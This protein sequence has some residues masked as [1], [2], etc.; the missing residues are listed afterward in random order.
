MA[1]VRREL[2]TQLRRLPSFVCLLLFLSAAIA[3]VLLAWPPEETLLSNAGTASNLLVQCLAF[4]LMGGC[5]LFVPSIAA[6]AIVGEKERET[7]DMLFLTL[8]RPSSIIIAKL[9]NTV[10]FFILLLV[11]VLPV[12]ACLFFLVGI[13]WGQLAAILVLVLA[14]VVTCAFVGLLSSA[15]FRRTF[16]A[17]VGAFIGMSVVM[18]I[19]PQFF[20]G[21]LMAIFGLRGSGRLIVLLA[22][23]HPLIA[24]QT[25]IADGVSV[26]LFLR[27][28]PQQLIICV[29][30][31]V[32]LL[33][34]LRRP[35]K[36]AHVD[37]R[38]PIDD[39]ELLHARRRRFPYYLIDP[40][41]RR[42]PIDDAHNPVAIRELR[43]G[44]F[45]R[46][47]RLIRLFYLTI[48][49]LFG[50]GISVGILQR[51][52]RSWMLIQFAL[53][54]VGTPALLANTLTKEHE[55]GNID[56]LR[57]T[58]LTP[59]QVIA[60]KFV[61]G[62]LTMAPTLAACLVAGVLMG[63][64]AVWWDDRPAPLLIGYPCLI[65]CAF[66]SLA[67]TFFASSSTRRTSVALLAS[68]LGSAVLFF[69]GL[70]VWQAVGIVEPALHKQDL[71]SYISPVTTFMRLAGMK[72][73]SLWRPERFPVWL[74]LVPVL[75]V[76][77]FFGRVLLAL[78]TQSFKRR[79][80]R[81]GAS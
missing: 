22:G 31:F 35:P 30:S 52:L 65:V 28:L 54:L 56:M 34:L 50:T 66:E 76:H 16:L 18:G 79:G 33:L 19:G 25:V 17:I 1:L 5:V 26:G 72:P 3:A 24:I 71:G 46:E 39:P 78:A 81:G 42:P 68:Y 10:A 63:F 64:G 48:I 49:I 40:L 61:A 47:T 62:V 6:N 36:P 4:V 44:L 58:L 74:A 7:Y 11:A 75:V 29:I 8:L 23:V 27:V 20:H 73:R 32:A 45:G 9:I 38:K 14:A 43:H 69:G 37:F 80:V 51:D 70:L 13:D 21:I 2:L 53:I 57:M 12:F 59:G 55:L 41:R 67:L 60:G 77:V 15:L